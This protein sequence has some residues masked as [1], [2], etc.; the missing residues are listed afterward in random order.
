[1]NHTT[2]VSYDLIS[3]YHVMKSH[4]TDCHTSR[5][6]LSSLPFQHNALQTPSLQIFRDLAMKDV[7]A[8]MLAAIEA[9]T[10]DRNAILDC[11]SGVVE[12]GVRFG[13]T[14]MPSMHSLADKW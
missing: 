7:Q 3:H 1:M 2:L 5:N 13:L 12:T 9:I 6:D 14:D 10:S 8:L 11:L 4:R